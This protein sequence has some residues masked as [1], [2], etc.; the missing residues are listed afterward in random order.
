MRSFDGI[1]SSRIR[2]ERSST[3]LGKLN[4]KYVCSC[5]IVIL[6]SISFNKTNK[7]FCYDSYMNRHARI[8]VYIGHSH[9]LSIRSVNTCWVAPYLRCFTFIVQQWHN[10]TIH[11]TMYACVGVCSH[12][13]HFQIPD[14]FREP[15]ETRQFSK[16]QCSRHPCPTTATKHWRI[17]SHWAYLWHDQ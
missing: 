9:L 7:M 2:L 15:Q 4:A 1:S 13:Q 5:G 11:Q 8:Y 3:V 6:Q 17:G 12:S 10:F 14:F 16:S